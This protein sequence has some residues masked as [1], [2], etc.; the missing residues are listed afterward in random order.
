MIARRKLALMLAGIMAGAAALAG[1]GAGAA[2][3][4]LISTRQGVYTEAQAAEGAQV[5]AGQCAMCHGSDLRGT[6][7][8]PTLKGKFVANWGHARL[9]ALYDYLGHAMPQFAPGQL[10][11]DDD[12]R[13]I[14]FLL[15]E[16]GYAAGAKP[17]PAD[18]M[19]LATISLEP[20]PMGAGK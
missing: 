3:P 8:V 15:K 1:A 12:A 20:L 19:A 11:P 6:Y 17:L 2:S 4:S 10:K 5:Y 14:A 7:E 16:N 13:L 18:S 9:S